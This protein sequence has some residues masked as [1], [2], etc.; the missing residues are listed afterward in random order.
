MGWATVGTLLTGWFM[1]TMGVLLLGA[2]AGACIKRYHRFFVGAPEPSVD[3]VMFCVVMTVL[4][5]TISIYVMAN[6]SFDRFDD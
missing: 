2:I 6:V 4:V 3:A 1:N 5:A